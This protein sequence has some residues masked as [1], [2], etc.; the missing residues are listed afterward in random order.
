MAVCR[1]MLARGLVNMEGTLY[2][3]G[4]AP[5]TPQDPSGSQNIKKMQQM[6]FCPKFGG[7][8]RWPNLV[9]HPRNFAKIIF[10][11]NDP[12]PPGNHKKQSKTQ[13]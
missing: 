9:P 10:F 11:S 1:L 7:Y 2:I 3:S 6:H 4:G 13:I 5:A 8:K 12:P